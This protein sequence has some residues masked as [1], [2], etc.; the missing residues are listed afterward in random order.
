MYSNKRHTT[1]KRLLREEPLSIWFMKLIEQLAKADSLR[2]TNACACATLRA[3][4]SVDYVLFTF[5]NCL[6]RA[7]TC[8]CSTCNAVITNY[9]CH[10]SKKKFVS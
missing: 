2:R 10:N 9:V 5:R 8:T 7:L 4:I 1:K 3:S 6:Y